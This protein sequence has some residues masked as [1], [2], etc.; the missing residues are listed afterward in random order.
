MHCV[1]LCSDGGDDD[2]NDMEKDDMQPQQFDEDADIVHSIN[3]KLFYKKGSEFSELGV[4]M[5]KVINM[6]GKTQV[7]NFCVVS[8][9]LVC[10]VLPVLL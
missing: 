3:A 1:C 6:D 5:F 10:L 7:S 8:C 2:D 4:G 9:C